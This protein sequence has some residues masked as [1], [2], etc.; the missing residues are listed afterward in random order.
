M[1][2]HEVTTWSNDLWEKRVLLIDYVTY[3]CY[4]GRCKFQVQRG[5][6]QSVTHC[7]WVGCILS[8]QSDLLSQICCICWR[9]A[10]GSFVYPRC[11]VTLTSADWSV[12]FHEILFK[13]T[14][15]WQINCICFIGLKERY[16]GLLSYQPVLI[17]ASKTRSG[18]TKL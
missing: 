14:K 4:P 7:D 8:P 2:F 3:H 6:S 18:R 13:H 9:W 12:Q 1:N 11:L 15:Q 5:V 16:T 17:T 10:A